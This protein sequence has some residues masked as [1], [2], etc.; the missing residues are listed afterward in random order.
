[1]TNELN[2]TKRTGADVMTVDIGIQLAK[3]VHCNCEPD[4]RLQISGMCK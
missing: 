2:F 1:M 4:W 3:G